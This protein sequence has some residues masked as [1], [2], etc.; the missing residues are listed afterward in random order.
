[1]EARLPA[2]WSAVGLTRDSRGRT[3]LIA[4]DGNRVARHF[5]DG[6]S[7]LLHETPAG[8]ASCTASPGTGLV[9]MLT[10]QGQLIVVSAVTGELRLAVQT[11]QVS[12]ASP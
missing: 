7:E 6:G 1:V 8:I 5:A 4:L 2:G 9:A 11:A 10:R 3:A 12:D